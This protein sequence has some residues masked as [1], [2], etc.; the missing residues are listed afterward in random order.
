M[1]L[2]DNSTAVNAII[3]F[4]KTLDILCLAQIVPSGSKG[5]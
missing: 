1:L 2:L 4:L 3:S 5:S